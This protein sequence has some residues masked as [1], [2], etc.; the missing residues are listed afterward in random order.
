[1]H[2]TPTAG[3]LNFS[4]IAEAARTYFNSAVGTEKLKMSGKY[5]TKCIEQRRRN[6]LKRVGIYKYNHRQ[7]EFTVTHHNDHDI[8][9]LS[10]LQPCMFSLI[11]KLISRQVA[12]QKSSATSE[13]DKEK[14]R[15]C[16]IEELISSEDSDEDGSFLVR[17]LPWRVDKVTN[18]FSHLDKKCDKRR[19]KKSRVM[20]FERKNGLPSERTKPTP[21]SVPAWTVTN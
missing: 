4:Y 10:T 20:I 9:H 8:H 13:Q 14:W 18:F 7:V 1:M 6:H 19:S 15:E 3:L 12:L 16:L 17:P 5:S 11:Q 21:G 2:L